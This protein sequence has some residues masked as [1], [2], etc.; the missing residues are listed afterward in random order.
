MMGGK[1]KGYVSRHDP[2]YDF[3]WR[4]MSDQFGIRESRPAFRVFGLTGSNEVYGYEEKCS[5]ARL[6][7]KFYGARFGWDGDKAA[8]LAHRE[9]R[10]LET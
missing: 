3:L 1:F 10:S 4:V 9:Y 2:M 7:C 6:I 8:G 5:G